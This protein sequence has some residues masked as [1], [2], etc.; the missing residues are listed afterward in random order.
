MRKIKDMSGLTIE[1]GRLINERPD[2]MTG[3]QMMANVKSAR[4]RMEKI[5]MIAQGNE[6]ARNQRDMRNMFKK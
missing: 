2:G 6:M 1:G 4:K 5:D 3:I